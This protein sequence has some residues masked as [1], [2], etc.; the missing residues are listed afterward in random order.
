M[1]PIEIAGNDTPAG[2]PGG[3]FAF[4]EP[5]GGSVVADLDRLSVILARQKPAWK[6]GTRQAR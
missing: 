2:A 3:L 6:P 4:D 1:P 5:V